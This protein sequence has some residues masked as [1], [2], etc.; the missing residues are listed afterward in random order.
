ML[1]SLPALWVEMRENVMFLLICLLIFVGLFVV[2]LLVERLWLK[3]PKVSASRRAAYIGIFSA[4]AAVLMYIEIPLFFAPSFYQMDLSEVPVFICSF[5]LG[6]VAGV[7]CELVKIILK[8]LLKGTS[9]AFVGDFANFVVGC[10]FVLPATIVYHRFKTK[11]GAL[12]GMAVGAGVMT[13]FGS[14]FNAVY[15]LPTFAELYGLPLDTLI[16]MGTAVNKAINSVSTLV[17]FA[18]VPFNLVKGVIVTI[19]TFLLYKRVERLL[20]MR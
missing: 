8:L 11:K 4:V 19:L 15:L 18:V 16:A 14:L 3:M 10:S 2:A 1:T 17:L 6:P 12:A 9:T 13:V 5:S 7:V 20:K